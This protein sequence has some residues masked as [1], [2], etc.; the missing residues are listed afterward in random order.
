MKIFVC[1]VENESNEKIRLSKEKY[2]ATKTKAKFWNDLDKS[3]TIIQYKELNK[4][5]NSI[6]EKYNIKT[7][8]L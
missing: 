6:N 1:L 4:V 2:I 3:S 7:N 8:V 5:I